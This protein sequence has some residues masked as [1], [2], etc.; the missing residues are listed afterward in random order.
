MSDESLAMA[1]L[2]QA[3][4]DLHIGLQGKT[5]S[6]RPYPG[7]WFRRRRT[8]DRQAR[9]LRRDAWEFFYGEDRSAFKFWLTAAGVELS[10]TLDPAVITAWLNKRIDDGVPRGWCILE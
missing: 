4:L 1:V 8:T 3:T 10:P 5:R 7:A 9:A 2:D 6:G